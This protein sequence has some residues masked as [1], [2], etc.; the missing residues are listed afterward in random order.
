MKQAN[1]CRLGAPT[2]H[3]LRFLRGWLEGPKMGGFPLL[4]RDRE[5]WDVENERDLVGLRPR[6]P[7]DRF[8]AWFS[9]TVLPTYHRVIGQKVKV[10]LL[11][12]PTAEGS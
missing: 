1:I 2:P 6:N 10:G 12:P 4:G 8:S 3:D 5:S 11:C 7:P 9:D